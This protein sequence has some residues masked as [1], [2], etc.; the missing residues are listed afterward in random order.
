MP[1]LEIADPDISFSAKT[2]KWRS[3]NL[4]NLSHSTP[5]HQ[6]SA[7]AIDNTISP[8]NNKLIP[9][10][11]HDKQQ[12]TVILAGIEIK[13]NCLDKNFKFEYGDQFFLANIY[14]LSA[15]PE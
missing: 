14:N 9:P 4:K 7:V 8:S 6:L 11:Q 2:F 12:N 5:I 15:Y 1:Y 3:S 13:K 10:S